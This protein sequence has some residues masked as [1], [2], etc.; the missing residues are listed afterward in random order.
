MRETDRAE[1]CDDR[2]LWEI[3]VLLSMRKAFKE[4]VRSL[5]HSESLQTVLWTSSS[6]NAEAFSCEKEKSSFCAK[7]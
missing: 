4:L 3:V 6:L 2:E 1:F 5:A 7:F